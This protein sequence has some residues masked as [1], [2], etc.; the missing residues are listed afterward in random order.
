VPIDNL[1]AIALGNAKAAA[2]DAQITKQETKI[3]NGR[4]VTAAT[5]SG[6]IEGIHFVYYSYYYSGK[7]GVVQVV[8]YTGANLLDEYRPELD[9][10]LDGFVG[11]P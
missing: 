6:T 2:P 3:V 1:L 10:F 8:T 11:G 7:G 4:E 5:I 9:Q